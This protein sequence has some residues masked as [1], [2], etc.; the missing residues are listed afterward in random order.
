MNENCF[1]KIINE[2]EFFD[3]D[4]YLALFELS[5]SKEL[6]EYMAL[7]MRFNIKIASCKQI[8]ADHELERFFEI[9]NKYIN[10]LRLLIK[11]QRS[12][13]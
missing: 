4:L 1:Q 7:L 3:N 6:D 5:I 8:K 11:Y 13:F 2:L 9:Q 12:S 10:L